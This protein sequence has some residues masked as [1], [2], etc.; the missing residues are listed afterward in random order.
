MGLE[1]AAPFMA[2]RRTDLHWYDAIFLGLA[3]AIVYPDWIL[4][5]L[6]ARTGRTLGWV[7]LILIEVVAVVLAV[8]AVVF[9]MP[10]YPKLEWWHPLLTVGLLAMIRAITAL[11]TSFLGFN[12]R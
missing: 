8:V 6:R 11:V 2:L 12:D 3:A 4:E 10:L 9:L 1:V 5:W 7:H